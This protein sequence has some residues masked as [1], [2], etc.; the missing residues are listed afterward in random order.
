MCP[1]EEP[2]LLNDGYC[3]MWC[4]AVLYEGQTVFNR[5]FLEVFV[6]IYDS[7][8]RISVNP[9]HIFEAYVNI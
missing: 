7:S 2:P 3:N 1:K 4:L 8:F 6:E 9:G 5:I